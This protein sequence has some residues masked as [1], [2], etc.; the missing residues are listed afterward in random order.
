VWLFDEAGAKHQVDDGTVSSVS[1]FMIGTE[2]VAVLEVVVDAIAVLE[3][4]V[5]VTVVIS[6]VIFILFEEK[7]TIAITV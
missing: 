6:F 4:A 7:M 2:E 1:K 5:V 3:V